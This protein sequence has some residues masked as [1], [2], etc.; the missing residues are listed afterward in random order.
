MHLIEYREGE[1]ENQ[2]GKMERVLEVEA[3]EGCREG[4]EEAQ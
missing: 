2:R 4:I 3:Y 1:R